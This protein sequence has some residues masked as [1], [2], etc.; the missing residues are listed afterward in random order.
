MPRHTPS[1]VSRT[2]RSWTVV[3]LVVAAATAPAAGAFAQKSDRPWMKA[4][5]SAVATSSLVPRP[6][7]TAVRTAH[8]PDY[9]G[10]PAVRAIEALGSHFRVNVIEVHSDRPKGIVDV[11]HPKDVDLVFGSGV[12]LQV[13]DGSPPP[14]AP[15]SAPQPTAPT[16]QAPQDPVPT[17]VPPP[18]AQPVP[19]PPPGTPAPMGFIRDF[20]GSDA[21][22]ARLYLEKVGFPVTGWYL[23]PSRQRRGMVLSQT[24]KNVRAP[25]GTPVALA[26]SKGP[27]RL[28]KWWP[29]AAG[30]VIVAGAAGG[31]VALRR[32]LRLRAQQRLLA[33]VH[34]AADLPA[35][36]SAPEFKGP[37][38][39][40]HSFIISAELSPQAPSLGVGPEDPS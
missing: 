31:G 21:T 27:S 38:G 39:P 2:R 11:Q 28:P 4:A 17:P 1:R 40:P 26:V 23:T 20:E 13:S 29:L 3:A 22:K 8:L 16:P 6:A 30:A 15:P 37:A 35:P 14:T 9:E 5:M 36:A 10:Y 24:P 25:L 7:L 19:A 18:P 12:E 32:G 34:V 33:T